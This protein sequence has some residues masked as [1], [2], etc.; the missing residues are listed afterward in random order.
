MRSGSLLGQCPRDSGLSPRFGVLATDAELLLD[1]AGQ[2]PDDRGA[3]LRREA[4]DRPEPPIEH[5]LV[6][7]A[8]K[9]YLSIGVDGAFGGQRD[10]SA[11]EARFDEHCGGLLGLRVERVVT[12]V[13][14]DAG[15]SR[16]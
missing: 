14:G 7:A 4:R 13:V 15:P 10:E 5:S 3:V 12:T 6:N 2:S 1:L 9:S 16:H 11:V 8:G